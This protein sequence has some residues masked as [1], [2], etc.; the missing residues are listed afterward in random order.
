MKYF[1]ICILSCFTLLYSACKED[2]ELVF[3]DMGY[4]YFP[5]DSGWIKVYS[6]DSISYNDNTQTIDTF[7][8]MLMETFGT[9]VNGQG[10]ENHR[11]VSRM[12]LPDSASLWE[13]RNSAY[14][15]L[16]GNTLQWVEEGIRIVKIVFPVGNTLS[17]NGNQYNNEGKR[18]FYLQ[19][20]GL[21]Y[22]ASDTTYPDCI[23]IQEANISNPVE[24]IQRKSIYARKLGLVDYKNLYI[25]TQSSV[26]SGY[27]VHQQL[28]YYSLP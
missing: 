27:S 9:E 25:N 1:T 19:N 11:E 21:P 12:V 14:F 8:F 4:D 3:P 2:K 28:K 10:L 16:N 15:K 7:H 22:V 23:S 24:Q 18:T 20:I 13:N 5:T 6:V 17:W 26:Q